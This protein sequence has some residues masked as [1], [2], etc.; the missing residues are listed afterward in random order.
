MNSFTRRT[1]AGMLG[2]AALA[3]ALIARAQTAP[4]ART[5]PTHR[6]HPTPQPQFV[7][8]VSWY[9]NE[10]GYSNRVIDL[11]THIAKA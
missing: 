4:H 6:A 8:L 7:K 1:L 5:D 10:A 2:A 9:D 3:P 11:V